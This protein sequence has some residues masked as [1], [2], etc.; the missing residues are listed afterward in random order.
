MLIRAM[1]PNELPAIVKIY[2]DT[3]NA[4]A[5][6]YVTESFI[7]S[8]TYENAKQRFEGI[9]NK[10]ERHPFCYVSEHDNIIIGY[11]IGGLAG[12]PPQGYQGELKMIYVLPSYQRMGI[13]QNLV[14]AVA[15]HFDRDQVLSVFLGV[16]KGNDPARRFYE[17]LGGL[18]I[19]EQITKIGEEKLAVTTYGWPSVGNL[20]QHITSLAT[21]EITTRSSEARSIID[22]EYKGN[23]KH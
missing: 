20:V 3:L 7:S 13:G 21:N 4:T 1:K 22:S 14:R 16:F 2:V 8:L 15:E 23:N 6:E 10:E 11:A 9:L 18:K 17:T 12:K 19:D 5:H